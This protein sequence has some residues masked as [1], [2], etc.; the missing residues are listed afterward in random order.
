MPVASFG[1]F[2]C[3]M[4]VI[5][6]NVKKKCKNKLLPFPWIE[7]CVAHKTVLITRDDLCKS[8]TSITSQ[9]GDIEE[10]WSS[11]LNAKFCWETLTFIWHVDSS[12]SLKKSIALQQRALFSSTGRPAASQSTFLQFSWLVRCKIYDN[13]AFLQCKILFSKSKNY[14]F[15]QIA[16]SYR[17]HLSMKHLKINT[18]Q[19]E[20]RQIY[21]T[22]QISGTYIVFQYIYNITI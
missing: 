13:A 21:R 2:P 17:S 5:L 8:T 16:E 6:L 11:Y 4:S 14:S 19:K 10:H 3:K 12:L 1:D 7:L 15:F 9:R 20:L 18:E 22:K